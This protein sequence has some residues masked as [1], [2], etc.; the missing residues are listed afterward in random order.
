MGLGTSWMVSLVVQPS[1]TIMTCQRQF[2]G[3][4]HPCKMVFPLKVTLQPVLWKN[5]LQPA[6]HRTATE[7]RLLT[8]PGSQCARRALGDRLLRSTFTGPSVVNDRV[9]FPLAPGQC[10]VAAGQS[11]LGT[12]G[13]HGFVRDGD[14]GIGGKDLTF[15]LLP[16]VDG[17]GE[18]GVDAGMEVCHVVIQIRFTDLGVGVKDVHD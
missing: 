6:S 8:R 17:K 5:T 1:S 10:H 11:V 3:S 2:L 12:C 15:L 18:A 16:C 7:R 14:T 4:R 9:T 13:D